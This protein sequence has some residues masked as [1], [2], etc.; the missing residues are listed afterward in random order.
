[1]RNIYIY[2]YKNKITKLK[3]YIL[4]SLGVINCDLA[5]ALK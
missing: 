4:K 2:I 1:M 3:K 5:V